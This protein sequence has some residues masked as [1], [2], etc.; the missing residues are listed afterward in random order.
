MP[1]SPTSPRFATRCTRVGP[2]IDQRALD[3]TTA[4]PMPACDLV[5]KARFRTNSVPQPSLSNDFNVECRRAQLL[6]QRQPQ[7]EVAFRRPRGGNVA[8]ID[9]VGPAE[10]P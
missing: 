5:T 6:P 1:C 7:R 4:A 3:G 2:E 10:R 8:E 9:C